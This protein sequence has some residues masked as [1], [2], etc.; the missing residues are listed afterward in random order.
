MVI[1]QRSDLSS[2]STSS[3]PTSSIP[4]SAKTWAIYDL[5]VRVAARASIETPSVACGDSIVAPAATGTDCRCR[6]VHGDLGQ[7]KAPGTY[8]GREVRRDGLGGGGWVPAADAGMTGGVVRHGP[9]SAS[10]G[11]A[12]HAGGEPGMGIARKTGGSVTPPLGGVVRL[13]A[14]FRLRAGPA[15]TPGRPFGRLRAGSP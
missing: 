7:S 12:H 2:K 13:G 1:F 10:S 4:S 3:S 5:A 8:K 15:K 11:R 9:P 14:P 6:P